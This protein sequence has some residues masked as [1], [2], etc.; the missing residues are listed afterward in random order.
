MEGA[1]ISSK[2]PW[3]D[4]LT[5]NRSLFFIRLEQRRFIAKQDLNLLVP[6]RN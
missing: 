4:L 6:N 1:W 2:S 3:T 5:A